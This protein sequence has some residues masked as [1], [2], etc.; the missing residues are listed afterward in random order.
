MWH[1]REALRAAEPKHLAARPPGMPPLM[2]KEYHSAP[3]LPK[4]MPKQPFLTCPLMPVVVLPL[5]CGSLAP[6]TPPPSSI[7]LWA[8]T[9]PP[10]N[11]WLQCKR[12]PPA[13]PRPSMAPYL[14]VASHPT[15]R[16]RLRWKQPCPSIVAHKDSSRQENGTEVQEESCTYVR[17]VKRGRQRDSRAVSE[18]MQAQGIR[19]V[20]GCRRGPAGFAWA[21]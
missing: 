10:P 5:P 19:H 9:T 12:P 13:P 2:P 16:R 3:P 8:P 7:G 1:I 15:K 6:H 20:G 11:L 21:M 17:D 18:K 4:R 14:C